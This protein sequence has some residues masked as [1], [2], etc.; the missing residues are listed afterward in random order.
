M[1]NVKQNI[2][3]YKE[4]AK[5]LEACIQFNSTDIAV[6]R[7]IYE[8]CK[9]DLFSIEKLTVEALEK[10]NAKLF[11][12]LVE[13]STVVDKSIKLF[14]TYE[15]N[16]KDGTLKIPRS[17]Y[18]TTYSDETKENI[19]RKHSDRKKRNDRKK[20][21]KYKSVHEESEDKKKK[22][23]KS[24]GN[25]VEDIKGKKSKKKKY[26]KIKNKKR[27]KS[28]DI[29]EDKNIK[30][31]INDKH[32]FTLDSKYS[33]NKEVESF[34][35]TN[36]LSSELVDDTHSNE[37]KKKK[38]KKKN[39]EKED[40][41]TIENN[42]TYTYDNALNSNKNNYLK[43][44]SKDKTYDFNIENSSNNSLI[45]IVHISEIINVLLDIKSVYIYLTLKSLD[46]KVNIKKRSKKKKVEKFTI[47]ISELFE[48]SIIYNNQLFLSID[49]ID[50]E[51]NT[52]YYTCLINLNKTIL[53]KT[54]FFTPTA[55]LLTAVHEKLHFKERGDNSGNL[56]N[57]NNSFINRNYCN[58]IENSYNNT[59]M[60][61]YKSIK[62]MS[63]ALDINNN[64]DNYYRINKTNNFGNS[65]NLNNINSF[66]NFG[67]INNTSIKSDKMNEKE[68]NEF[69]KIEGEVS[70]NHS[71][72]IMNIVLKN[73]EFDYETEVIIENN[74]NLYKELYNI[75]NKEKMFYENKNKENEKKIEELDKTV[76]LLELDN[77]NYVQANNKLKEIINGKKEIIKT[78]EK[79]I[80]KKNS[81]IEKLR[82][83]NKKIDEAEK[84]AEENKKQNSY[85]SQKISKLNTSF[86]EYKLKLENSS[87]VNNN[88]NSK[89]N[90]LLFQLQNAQF[91]N[92]KL[93]SYLLFL[94]KHMH[95]FHYSN[96]DNSFNF[97][98]FKKLNMKFSKYKLDNYNDLLT[99]L[100]H[101]LINEDIC[102]NSNE[103]F[104][105]I[106][107]LK[108]KK[109][110]NLSLEYSDDLSKSHY[111]KENNCNSDNSLVEYKNDYENNFPNI[112][113]DI[114]YKIS[115]D[116]EKKSKDKILDDA[117]TDEF[118]IQQYKKNITFSKKKKEK[119]DDNSDSSKKVKKHISNYIHKLNLDNDKLLD[120]DQI[121]NSNLNIKREYDEEDHSS[122]NEK[123]EKENNIHLN[124]INNVK[125]VNDS[126]SNFNEILS[127]HNGINSVTYSTFSF[128]IKNYKEK[129]KKR[130]LF[131]KK[132]K[133][134]KIGKNTLKY[135]MENNHMNKCIEDFDN[136]SLNEKGDNFSYN[137]DINKDKYNN[138]FTGM[139]DK[140]QK[141][142]INNYKKKRSS[143]V[144]NEYNST[145]NNKYHNNIE[146]NETIHN[147]NN[148]KD[149]EKKINISDKTS[150]NVKNMEKKQKLNNEKYSLY[151]ENEK[152]R[153]KKVE[154]K[155]NDNKKEVNKYLS[156]KDS[157][158]FY[159]INKKNTNDY[160]SDFKNFEKKYNYFLKVPGNHKETILSKSDHSYVVNKYKKNYFSNLEKIINKCKKKEHNISFL[161]N[162]LHAEMN[163]K[164]TSHEEINYH[165]KLLRNFYI[166]NLKGLIFKNAFV[167]I[168]ANIYFND[169][170]NQKI[171]KG[172][173]DY[174]D[175]FEDNNKNIYMNI[176]IKSIFYSLMYIKGYINENKMEN[177]TVIKR[178]L[179]NNN[180]NNNIT[181]DNDYIYLKKNEICLLYELSFNS[182]YLINL[183]L[184]LNIECLI[185]DNTTTKFKVS[186]PFVHLFL[187]KPNSLYLNN[188][189]KNNYGGKYYYKAYFYNMMDFTSFDEFI[190]I[191]KLR[192][193]FKIFHFNSYIILYTNYYFD[194][195]KNPILLLLCDFIKN[196]NNS[197]GIVKLY[198]ISISDELISF[199]INLFKQ[200]L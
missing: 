184:F 78:I 2:L 96:N 144:Y 36:S 61:N 91:K 52:Y 168:Y 34:Y 24:L 58:N 142:N 65:N 54:K 40:S 86:V 182:S 108:N 137:S 183:P 131:K 196:K 25:T 123:E 180:N 80:K 51:N 198:F 140:I 178:Y 15:K 39:F 189:I 16:Q 92:E 132:D 115:S 106:K 9:K 156:F 23:Y 129:S 136:D 160:L 44:N 14:E 84:I 107:C 53:K 4:L 68:K 141:E 133:K 71:Y 19:K 154:E 66:Q 161:D 186:L 104:N 195:K 28:Y 30:K 126:N 85:L 60:E 48:F 12:E 21:K 171:Y 192:N 59:Q 130:S 33:F 150:L 79:I 200:I 38:K 97:L 75:C 5:Q 90:N 188:F 155:E 88:L 7:D 31:D 134:N 121:D 64:S 77:E 197:N 152:S 95:H 167:E 13:A 20:D 194:D 102:K 22:K 172:K 32:F 199:S 47:D 122:V 145:S 138:I 120:N 70:N 146:K 50:S 69:H 190:S 57:K 45:I 114:S 1:N 157:E 148:K 46:N 153:K 101:N 37:K 185:N 82:K 158:C 166:K 128:N 181:G 187:F 147:M 139:K 35:N 177:I 83:E 175:I 191:L 29:N 110:I 17:S 93:L 127:S 100:N 162:Y 10:G 72:V 174:L 125:I 76:M 111:E 56:F 62:Y 73:N 63:N 119:N 149:L 81:K 26:E 165:K 89:I 193:S 117:L 143:V 112:Y 151:L 109:N 67:N 42:Y 99:N 135:K 159:D 49:I 113:E 179:K 116:K 74:I 163:S 118:L 94:L 124:D 3:N 87:Q 98:N 164:F 169:K 176:Y 11:E 8:K 103:N 105:S 43:H 41:S 170:Y 55:F 173:S 6:I 27:E 18:H